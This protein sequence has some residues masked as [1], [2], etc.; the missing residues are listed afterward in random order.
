V[1]LVHYPLTIPIPATSRPAVVTL[2]DVQH[3]DLPSFFSRAERALRTLTYDRAAKE[4]TLVVTPSAYSAGRIEEVLGVPGDR[5][6]VI[7]SG[8]DHR[9]FDRRPV[10][11]DPERLAPLGLERPFVLYPAN[12]WPHKNHERL[13]EAFAR[14]PVP[15]LE[16]VLTGM[17]YSQAAR[18]AELARRAGAAERVR[19]VG[20]V[21]R[22]AMPAMYRAARALVFPSL[23]EGFG[24]PPLEAMA[25]GCPVASSTR[26]SLGEL[27]AGACVELDPESTE[28]I[29]TGIERLVTDEPLREQLVEAGL[30]RARSFSWENSMRSHLAAYAR[31]LEAGAAAAS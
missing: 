10:A 29:A 24:G 31:A 16:L 25:S 22:D 18:I 7:P 28:S 8:V 15:E 2:H 27:V 13:I 20:Y 6:C 23:Y 17:T 4:A 9:R 19:H 21:D 14:V 5:I 1:D 12:L 3:H 30:E 11:S 26:A